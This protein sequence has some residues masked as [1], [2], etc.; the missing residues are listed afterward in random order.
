M[1]GKYVG[2]NHPLFG[3]IHSE[4]TKDKMSR[5]QG[6]TIFVYSLDNQLLHTF[7]SAT[8]AGIFFKISRPTVLKYARSREI[9]K[10]KYIF[11]LEI[12]SPSK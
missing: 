6:T 7:T 2:D 3:K 8:K 12:N 1:K 9:Y 11:S 10:E 5:A 4:A